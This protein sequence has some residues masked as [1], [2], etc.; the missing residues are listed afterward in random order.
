METKIYVFTIRVLVCRDQDSRE[1]LAHALE[2]DIVAYG[3]TEE[4][5]IKQLS[6]LIECQI[7]FA[8]QQGDDNLLLFPAP[9]EYFERWETAHAAAL[10]E[11]VLGDKSVKV[12]AKAIC[13]SF[14]KGEIRQL[15]RRRLTP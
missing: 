9:R 4:I 6:E 15:I 7:S 3:R 14:T 5:A 12:K 13:I 8:A 1:F 2:M 11:Q 10:R